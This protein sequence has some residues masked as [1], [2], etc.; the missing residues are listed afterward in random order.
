MC[1]FCS[2]KC[3]FIFFNMVFMASGVALLT[4][5]VLHN[6]TFQEL[7]E[8]A[9]KTLTKIAIVLIAVGSIITVVSILGCLGAF[10]DNYKL[11]VSFLCCLIIIILMEIITGAIVYTFYSKMILNPSALAN[12]KGSVNYMDKMKMIISE[13]SPEKRAAIDRIQE[14]LKCCGADGPDDWATSVGWEDHEATPDSCC[15]EKGAGCGKEKDKA[16]KKGCIKAIYLFL[17][18]RLMAV[19]VICI[20]LAIAECFGVFIGALF[21]C[22]IKQ[23]D[24]DNMS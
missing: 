2:F 22:K 12:I 6:P 18:K 5:G 13:Y 21:S 15:V 8:I 16:S 7:G 1:T 17:G 11:V 4:I 3:G 10:F 19:G 23:K 20:C 9:G 14:K 24:Y